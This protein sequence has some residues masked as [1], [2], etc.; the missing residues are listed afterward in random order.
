M[1]QKELAAQG[2]HH[3]ANDVCIDCGRRFSPSDMTTI[4]LPSDT[5]SIAAD[6]F[7]GLPAQAVV[8]PSVCKQ[9]GEG[10]FADNPALR[11]LFAP[12]SL[13]G[14]IPADA[15]TGSDPVIVYYGCKAK[16]VIT[17]DDGMLPLAAGVNMN[18]GDCFN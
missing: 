17:I 11:Y 18:E 10:A 14:K 7:R 12:V 2:A 5:V 3:T 6:S 9:I 1:A 15:L 8:L 4:R 13:E 16:Q